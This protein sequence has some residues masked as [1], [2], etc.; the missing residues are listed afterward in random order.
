MKIGI[1]NTDEVKPEFAAE[2]GQYPDM[3]SRILLAG[4]PDIEVVTYEV[5]RGDYPSDID[6][7]DAYIITGS[8]LSVYDDVPWIRALKDFVQQLHNAKKKLIGICFGHQLVAEALGGK[9]RQATQGWCVGVHRN[10]LTSEAQ[11]YGITAPDF[12]LLSNHRDQVETMATGAKLLA[13]TQA[14][15]I[16]MTAIGYHI[17]TLQGH[18]EFDKGYARALLDMRREILGE[19]LY[20]AA[21][22]SLQQTPDNIT[23]A[24]WILDFIANSNLQNSNSVG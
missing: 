12:Q 23:V 7:V 17:L 16:S 14:C 21:V 5:V 24:R 11:S 1:L 2:F 20:N 13:S 6:E 19:A 4:D 18:P 10:T 8:K 3:F 15:P 9:T 22:D